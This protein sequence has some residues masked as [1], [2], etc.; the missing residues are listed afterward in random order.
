MA[1]VIVI[2]GGVVGA[3]TAWQLAER[4]AEVLLLERGALAGGATR[5]SQGLLLDPD[6]AEMQPLFE[7]SNQLYD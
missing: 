2:G 6:H 7:Q 1:D 3:C 4:G 5:R